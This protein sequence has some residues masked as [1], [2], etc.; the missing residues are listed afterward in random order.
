[1]SEILATHPLLLITIGLC[2]VAI[3]T[4]AY[5]SVVIVSGNAIAVLERR[6]I[7]RKMPQGRVVAMGGEVGIQARTFGPGMHFL[8]PFLYVASKYDFMEISNGEIGS[9]E[10]IDG[11]P[12]PPGRIFASVVEGHNAFQDGEAFLVNGGQK[13]PQI[14][15]LPPGKYRINPYLFHVAKSDAVSVDK[16]KVG[17]VTS[18]DG[19]QI[20]AGRLLAQSVPGHS[21]FEDGQAFLEKGGQKGPQI[22]ILRPGTY[23]I[24]LNLF[25]VEIHEATVVPAGKIGLVT[26]L[27]GSPLPEN[28]FIAKSVDVH[29]D[30]QDGPKFLAGDGQR[31]PQLDVLRPG[32]YYINPLMFKVELD[33]VAIVERGQVAVVIS[34]VGE[35]PTDE[36]KKRLTSSQTEGG[37]PVEEEA[38]ER[39]VV[40]KGFRGIQ[41]EVAGP[42]RYYLNKRAFIPYIIDTTNITIDWDSS[43]DTRF[44]QLQVISKDGFPID[45][46]VKVVVRVRP[47]QAPYLVAKIGSIENLIQ[48]VIHPMIDSSFRNQAS[49]T[50][51]MNFMQNRQNEQTNAEERARH[52]L[53]KYHVE[54]VSVLICQIKL[55]QELMETQTRRIIAEQQKEMFSM[56][57]EAEAARISTEKTRATA[58]QQ[59]ELVTAEIGVKVAEQ[60][61]QKTIVLAQ[62]D[63]EGVRLRGEGEAKRIEAI[64]QATAAAY[65]KQNEALGQEAV[66]AIE[67]IKKIAEG[68]VRITPDILVSGEKGGLLDILFAQLVRK[69]AA[70]PGKSALMAAGLAEHGA[71]AAVA[72]ALIVAGAEEK[73]A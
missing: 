29:D 18:A 13:G 16:G 5:Y 40:P 64:G 37:Q 20:P 35:E 45:V 65:R 27:D 44:D 56:Q 2:T 57:Q 67:L 70:E 71:T 12:I 39:Y 8:I 3:L 41:E 66:T 9:V 47:D 72:G 42:G 10:S 52:G 50:S 69:G 28:E 21:N 59:G 53:E 31:G 46:S 25:K 17:V 6:W 24:N 43:D 68:G 38:R 61:K 11:K 62:G 48:H 36:M 51:A 63:A 54:C 49:S 34:N 55:P 22:D 15:I 26:A 19:T 7:G 33:D 23:R 58:N 32:T 1:M 73:G 60:Q 14:Q 4:L 30:Y